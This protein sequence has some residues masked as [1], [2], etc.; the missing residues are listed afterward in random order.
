MKNVTS[1]SLLFMFITISAYS[2]AL[3]NDPSACNF[4][5]NGSSMVDCVYI[6]DTC[7][8][9]S[10]L[11]NSLDIIDS[12]CNC[13]NYAGCTNPLACNYDPEFLV[14]DGTCIMNQIGIEYSNE[15]STTPNAAMLDFNITGVSNGYLQI[16]INFGPSPLIIMA[17]D[18]VSIG[19]IPCG[20]TVGMFV[21][22]NFQNCS[23]TFDV[24]IDCPLGC[25]DQLACNFD[26]FAV[27]NDSSCLAMPMC[28]NDIC[29]GDLEQINPTNPCN[30]VVV[31]T[32][33]LGC[34]D[35]LAINYDAN[36]NCD[37]GTCYLTSIF[38]INE[39]INIY[40]NPTS[41]TIFIQSDY[42]YQRIE[43]I[44]LSGKQV[45][46]LEGMQSQINVSS[47]LSGI[48][49]IKFINDEQERYSKFSVFF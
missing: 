17:T 41:H 20:N 42:I 35:S 47:L 1:F 18:S 13:I 8:N 46:K 38:D 37:D 30:C 49:W 10:I 4:D 16:D 44:D 32:Q 9:T 2:Q 27:I 26:P 39:T 14:D 3:C 6:G 25:T 33:V 45:M 19:P 40:P 23:E 11:T 5:P 12:L 22:S 48:Y 43:V 7:L 31:D 24:I 28:N 21:Y 36:A 15:P 34:M 29:L